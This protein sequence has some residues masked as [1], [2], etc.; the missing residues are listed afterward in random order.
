MLLSLEIGMNSD[1]GSQGQTP[2]LSQQLR[3]DGCTSVGFPP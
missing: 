1:L 3:S 2:L